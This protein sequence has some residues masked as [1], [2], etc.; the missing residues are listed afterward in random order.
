MP[1]IVTCHPHPPTYIIPGTYGRHHDMMMIMVRSEVMAMSGGYRALTSSTRDRLL[2]RQE[3][4]IETN[5]YLVFSVNK[6]C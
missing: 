6:P 3:T 2:F 1:P 4:H 5:E